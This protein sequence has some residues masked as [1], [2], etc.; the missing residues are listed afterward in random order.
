M[1]KIGL[2]QG[3][4]YYKH[5][6]LWEDFFSNL[7]FAVVKSGPTNKTILDMGVRVTESESCLPVKI[8]Y[9]HCL[10]LIDQGVDILFVPRYISLKKKR[11]GCPKFF[12]IG[13]ILPSMFSGMPP[14]L[15]PTIDANKKTLGDSMV[16]AAVKLKIMPARARRAASAALAKFRQEKRL[17]VAQNQKLL[18]SSR[19]KVLLISHPY[20]L[21]DSFINANLVTQLE[22]LGVVPIMIDKIAVA[23]TRA[24]EYFFHWD[25]AH[26]MLNQID[27]VIGGKIDGGIQLSTFNCGCDSVV[28]EFVEKKFRQHKVPY[29]PLI[30]DEHTAEAGLVTRLEAFVDTLNKKHSQ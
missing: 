24:Q 3:F 15:A 28:K 20:N 8:Y 27:A 22:S 10:K 23:N 14:V 29:M 5:P 30:I 9:G 7:G 13:D 4:I 18:Q 19:I 1:N 16:E 25:F 26:D 2:P 11:L 17:R 12:A 21:Y 6:G